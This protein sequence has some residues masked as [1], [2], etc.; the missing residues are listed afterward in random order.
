MISVF[1]SKFSMAI[2]EA[3]LAGMGGSERWEIKAGAQLT[4]CGRHGRDGRDGRRDRDGFIL[5]HRHRGDAI[6]GS[7]T[8]LQELGVRKVGP[9]TAGFSQYWKEARLRP[10]V[11]E[12]TGGV[13]LRRMPGK[14]AATRSCGW[15]GAS[16]ATRA[17]CE[18]ASVAAAE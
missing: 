9:D 16:D 10:L 2:G 5:V 17:P 12:E 6:V 8:G 4:G 18:A 11:S 13:G 1:A 3:A 15:T 7:G 14:L